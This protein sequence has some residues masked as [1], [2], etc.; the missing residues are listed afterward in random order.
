VLDEGDVTDFPTV[1]T[2]LST[3]D[4]TMKLSGLHKNTLTDCSV[5]K[6]AIDLYAI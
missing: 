4:A 2:Q 3:T 6:A 5:L 1:A